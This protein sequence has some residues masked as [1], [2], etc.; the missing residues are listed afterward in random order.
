MQAFIERKGFIRWRFGTRVGW[1]FCGIQ[2]VLVLIKI[3]T[4]SE[5]RK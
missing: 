3:G 1:S 2:T 5:W 4:Y